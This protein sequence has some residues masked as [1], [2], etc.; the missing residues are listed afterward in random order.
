[1]SCRHGNCIMTLLARAATLT[2][3]LDIA[4]QLVQSVF[5]SVKSTDFGKL[6]QQLLRL[7]GL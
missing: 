2:N 3:Y 4:R 5:V 1:M 7:L 6:V